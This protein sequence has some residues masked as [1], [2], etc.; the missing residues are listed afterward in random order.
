MTEEVW[1]DEL[2][3]PMDA[4][5]FARLAAVALPEMKLDAYRTWIEALQPPTPA[6]IE[7]F[8]DYVAGAR[9]WYKHLPLMPPGVPFQFYIDPHAGMDRLVLP[10]GG[11]R[12]RER[13]HETEPF[14]YSWMTTAEYHL[15][16]GHLAFSCAKGSLLFTDEYCDGEPVLVDHNSFFP[17]LRVSENEAFAPPSEVLDAGRCAMITL[18]HPRATEKFVATQLAGTAC[19]PEHR[20]DGDWAPVIDRWREKADQCGDV[21]ELAGQIITDPVFVSRFH[22]EKAQLRRNMIAAMQRVCDLAYPV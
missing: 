16:F 2:E 21:G 17:E 15:R 22:K 10:S 6:Q 11:V 3:D 12:L 18:V 9:S 19:I 7:A 13:T 20:V 1:M 5:M 14:H 4:M 8:A